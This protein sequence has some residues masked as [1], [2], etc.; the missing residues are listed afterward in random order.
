KNFRIH[1]FNSLVKQRQSL[2]VVENTVKSFDPAEV[3]QMVEE[4][5]KDNLQPRQVLEHNEQESKEE[6]EPGA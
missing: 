2:T 1:A 4:G 3:Q 6:G 5:A